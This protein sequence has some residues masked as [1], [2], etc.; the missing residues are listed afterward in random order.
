MA[1]TRP[2]LALLAAMLTSIGGSA[3]A[4][5]VAAQTFPAEVRGQVE[6]MMNRSVFAPPPSPTATC[7]SVVVGQESKW[8]A[9]AP[10]KRVFSHHP[11]EWPWIRQYPAG[12]NL[13]FCQYTSR[14]TG[15]QPEVSYIAEVVTLNPTPAQLVTWMSSACRTAIQVTGAPP[16]RFDECVRGLYWGLPLQAPDDKKKFLGIRQF[17]GGKFVVSGA[18]ALDASRGG[19]VCHRDGVAL[20]RERPGLPAIGYFAMTETADGKAVK[21]V[22]DGELAECF[23]IG[24]PKEWPGGSPAQLAGTTRDQLWNALPKLGRTPAEFG[25][26][27]RADLEPPEVWRRIVRESHLAALKS[28]NHVLIDAWVLAHAPDLLR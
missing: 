27:A 7:G 19:L 6:E 26:S 24:A 8:T 11:S 17:S 10:W 20:L 15:T 25:L 28:N 3:T 16:D 21:Q 23:K 14:V 22:T 18:V 4:Q 12:T 2:S 9:A 1:K 13:R 5:Q